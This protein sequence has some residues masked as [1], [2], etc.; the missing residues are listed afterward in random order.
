M[1]SIKIDISRLNSFDEIVDVY[2]VKW[3]TKITLAKEMGPL[4]DVL[5]KMRMFSGQSTI[6]HIYRGFYFK[7]RGRGKALESD[8]IDD[9]IYTVD[10]PI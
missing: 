5:V 2:G 4:F 7:G 3:G 10:R 1:R 6:T 8:Y 9:M